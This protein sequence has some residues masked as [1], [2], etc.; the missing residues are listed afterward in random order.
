MKVMLLTAKWCP[1]CPSA[2]KI[3][4]EA[5]KEAKFDYEEIDIE[6]PKGKELVDKHSVMSIPTTILQDESGT[7]KVAFVGVPT[8]QK[9]L[10]LVKK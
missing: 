1:Y 4:E 6:T 8:K 10:D 5:R 7:Q 2:K 3:W 9:A